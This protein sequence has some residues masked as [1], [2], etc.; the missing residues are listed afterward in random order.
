MAEPE[1]LCELLWPLLSH[2]GKKPMS[3]DM[4]LHTAA[5]PQE[6]LGQ[7]RREVGALTD[8]S[9]IAEHPRGVA[10]DT[11]QLGNVADYLYY[12]C[13]YTKQQIK[14]RLKHYEGWEN[15]EWAPPFW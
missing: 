2:R 4:L 6:D 9:F 10:V 1:Y 14:I 5:I 7:A 12:N 11:S 15:H 8:L 13:E 3:I